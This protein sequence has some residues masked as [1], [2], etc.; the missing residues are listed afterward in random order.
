MTPAIKAQK[1]SKRFPLQRG[2]GRPADS[3]LVLNELDFEIQP[4]QAVGLIGRNGAGKST[5][6][7]ILARILPPT[8]GRVEIDGRVG[9]LLEAGAGFHPDLSGRDN[10]FL[11]GAMLGMKDAEIRRRLE[12][13]IDFSGVEASLDSPVK[14][15]STG[16][17]MR[18]AFA[19][20]A[21]IDP[22]ILLV[23]EVLAVGDAQFQ[24]KCMQRMETLRQNGQTV[25]FV[26]HSMQAVARLCER[27]YWL[28]SGKLRAE[29]NVGDVVSAYL[30]EGY[31]RAGEQQ[32]PDSSFAPG[33]G[34]VRLRRVRVSGL[35]GETASSIN[36]GEGFH[37]ECVYEVLTGG[38]VLF[39]V[40]RLFNEW[41]TEVL[42]ST[43]AGTP[44]HG[45]PR[46][47]GRYHATVHLP[48]NLLSE[49]HF[50]V[51]VSIVSLVP[52]RTHFSE[53]DAVHFQATEIID[54]TTARGDYIGSIGS[55]VRPKLKWCTEQEA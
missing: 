45:S 10:I 18:L 29:G 14:H 41:G 37:I 42:W 47:P 24:K 20:A 13:I 36:I 2:P 7:K 17:Y 30:K 49:G 44:E 53:P 4:G 28:D 39:P 50:S 51:E 5:L 1:L 34:V 35:D 55:V 8:S 38:S 33:D 6:L 48:G 21:H 9:C 54:G 11:A 43:D 26:S 27:A 25:L 3:F 40:I 15:Y 22:E 52:T 12:A 16:M 32:W 23:D 31:A 19:V 46:K